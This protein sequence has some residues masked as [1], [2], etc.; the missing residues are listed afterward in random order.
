MNR[1]FLPFLMS[2][3]F[4]L[5]IASGLKDY[6]STFSKSM[7]SQPKLSF[8]E[9]KAKTLE[10]K[11]FSFAS[12]KGKRVLIVN[13]ASECGFTP[14][15]KKLQKLFEDYKDK[16]FVI[17]AFPCNDF[18]GQEP[19]SATEIKSFCEKNYGVTFQLMEK[20]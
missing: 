11:D 4:S 20:V 5:L 8:Y 3:S 12:L 7:Q 1:A 14:Q 9:L 2:F 13:V 18:G 16:N 17:L 15:Y 6:L 19:G 10:G